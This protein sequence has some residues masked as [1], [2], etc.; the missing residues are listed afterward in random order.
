MIKI[1]HQTNKTSSIPLEL[2]H[3]VESV[4]KYHKD[5]NYMLWNDKD[6]DK[7]IKEEYSFIWDNY[8][9]CIGIQ[10]ADIARYCI[11]HKFG[12]LYVDT[13]MLF[14]TNIEPILD[15]KTGIILAPSIPTLPF[16]KNTATNYIIY[17]GIKENDFWI[18]L[19]KEI[20]ERLTSCKGWIYKLSILNALVIPYTTGKVVLTKYLND[21]LYTV[22]DSSLICDKHSP[23]Y[24]VN[25]EK[26]CCVHEGGSTRSGGKK[27]GNN[28]ENY[29]TSF[30]FKMRHIFN[31]RQ[32]SYQ[33]PLFSI[34]ATVSMLYF[35]IL[36]L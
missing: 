8:Q 26:V 21:D 25:S 15:G 1:I 31:I 28:I 14:Y 35:L 36:M 20:N 24:I 7:L 29:F 22:F 32:N 30:E 27:W 23:L 6:N 9:S 17:S 4:K 11:L 33:V 19:L 12:G 34:L 2:Q 16:I 13:D 18:I 10:K 3:Y 5:W